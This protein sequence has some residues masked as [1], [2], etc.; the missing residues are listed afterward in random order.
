MFFT[1]LQAELRGG[2]DHG[3]RQDHALGHA[4]RHALRRYEFLSI[5]LCDNLSYLYLYIYLYI[6]PSIYIYI[7]IYPSIHLSVSCQRPD[8]VVSQGLAA[9]SSSRARFAPCPPW[10]GRT[11]TGPRD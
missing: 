6:Y 3:Y 10:P 2:Q 8:T 4:H 5:Y 7:F 11:G 1:D 9:S